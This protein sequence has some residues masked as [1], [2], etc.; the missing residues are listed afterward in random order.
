MSLETYLYED[1]EG[2]TKLTTI[3]VYQTLAD[4]DAMLQSG[5]ED[6]GDET[7]ERAQSRAG[8]AIAS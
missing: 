6:G 1:H 8:R 3:S 4:R 5:M 7:M 2:G